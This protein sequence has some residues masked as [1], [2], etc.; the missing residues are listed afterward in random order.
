[1]VN[2]NLLYV[3]GWFLFNNLWWAHVTVIPEVNK[4]IVF[5]KGIL[6]GLKVIILVGGH[7]NPNS[8]VGVN[9]EWKKDQKKEKKKNTSE[10]INKIIPN[11]NPVNTCWVWCPWKDLSRV[12]SRH[13]WYMVNSTIIIPNKNKVILLWWNIFTTPVNIII[14]PLA[15]LIGQG[16]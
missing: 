7:N 14:V 11:F 4:I 1:M 2:S 12:T 5:N 10:I 13:H 15:L 6:N 3:C 9:L 16:L 8:I